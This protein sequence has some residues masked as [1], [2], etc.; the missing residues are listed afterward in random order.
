[1]YLMIYYYNKQLLRIVLL[2]LSLSFNRISIKFKK[3][4]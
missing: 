1:M 2:L 4:N 3:Q